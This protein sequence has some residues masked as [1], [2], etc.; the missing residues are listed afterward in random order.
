M[1][2]ALGIAGL[3]APAQDRSK[4]PYLTPEEAVAKMTI[5]SGFGVKVFAGE[6]DI[7][8]PIAFTFDDRGRIW[9]IEN[10]NYRTRGNHTGDRSTRI[11][12]LED[13]DGDGVADA[14][15]V[16][17]QDP[18]LRAPLGL[19][20][21]GNQVIVSTSPSLIVYTDTDGDDQPDHKETLLTGFGGYDHDHSLHALLAGPDGQWGI[22]HAEPDTDFFE[23]TRDNLYSYSVDR[24]ERY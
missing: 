10:L 4:V 24:P 20:V 5:P 21:I 1:E 7:G 2:S 8:Q 18:D 12:I 22:M 14:S 13:T 17:V 23:H 9:V 6:P 19:A 11:A 15:K 3:E 16:F